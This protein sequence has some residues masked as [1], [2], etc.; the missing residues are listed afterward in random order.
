MSK[1]SAPVR[2]T[3]DGA[4]DQTVHGP[5]AAAMLLMISWPTKSGTQRDRAERMCLAAIKDATASEGARDAFL[6]AI[7]EAGLTAGRESG[8]PIAA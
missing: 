1:W 7:E 5:Y 2:L 8:D 3:L 4:G 6:A